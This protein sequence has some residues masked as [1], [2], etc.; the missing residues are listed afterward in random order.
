[1]QRVISVTAPLHQTYIILRLWQQYCEPLPVH[2]I[3]PN[4]SLS[5][6]LSLSVHYQGPVRVAGLALPA[7]ASR[8]PPK[9]RA[10]ESSRQWA[11]WAAGKAYGAGPR[12]LKRETPYTRSSLKVT[13]MTQARVRKHTV[14]PK[15]STLV[16]R[17]RTPTMHTALRPEILKIHNWSTS[18][19]TP[20]ASLTLSPP[21]TPASPRPPASAPPGRDRSCVRTS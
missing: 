15:G 3:V 9:P 20:P 8:A 10:A 16:T 2:E 18:P 6:S 21:P 4:K 14:G 5:L 11:A 17:S 12:R 1:M 7:D 19:H 13:T